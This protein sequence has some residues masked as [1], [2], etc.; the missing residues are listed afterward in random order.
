MEMMQWLTLAIFAV[1]IL[2]AVSVVVYRA[3][4]R[5]SS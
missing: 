5:Q 1:T 4:R 3:S 2:A